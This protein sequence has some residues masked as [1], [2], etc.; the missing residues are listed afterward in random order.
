MYL[1]FQKQKKSKYGVK[2]LA[3]ECPASLGLYITFKELLDAIVAIPIL[4][5][6]CS[7]MFPFIYPHRKE[8][9]TWE[10]LSASSSRFCIF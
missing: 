2:A 6:R 8:V 3:S 10:T 5:A 7:P 4:G 1:M 9:K